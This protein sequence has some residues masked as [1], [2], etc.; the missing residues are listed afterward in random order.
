MT[1]QRMGPNIV[2][3]KVAKRGI[4]PV[5]MIDICRMAIGEK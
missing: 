4:K 2:G 3:A 5:H 1:W